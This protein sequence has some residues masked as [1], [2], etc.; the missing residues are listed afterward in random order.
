MT[1][2]KS[3]F[4]RL[5]SI[6]YAAFKGEQHDYTQGSINKAIVLLSIP[7]IIEMVMESLFAVIDI[8][9]VGKI[10]VNAIA[11]VAL[12][13]SVIMIIYSVAMGLSMAATALVAR[14]VGEKDYDGASRSAEQ[15]ILV[16]V[17]VALFFGIIGASFPRTILRLM[18]GEPD[19]IAEGYRYTMFM[20][21]GNITIML[22]FLI[23]AI[24]RGA[25]DASIAMRVLVLS[26][27]LNIILDPILIFGLG[28][29]PAFG[30]EG[31]AIAT[32]TGRGIGVLYQIYLLNSERTKIHL[33]NFKVRFIRP[34]VKSIVNISLGGIGQFMIGTVSW[35]LMVRISA[36]FGPDVLAGYAIAF[37]II[38]FTILP[39]WGLSNAAATLV[40]Q[41]LGAGNPERAEASVW[42]C[43]Y[44]NMI[45]LFA[46]SVIFFWQAEFFVGIFTSEAEVTRWGAMA[47]R[48][49]CT[50]YIFFAYGMVI[51]QAFNGAGDTKTPTIINIIC[52]WG[53]ELPLAYILAVTFGIGPAGIFISIA[54]AVVLVAVVSIVI[55]KK[56]KWK[57][58]KV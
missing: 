8:Y 22:I 17:A 20:F 45:F 3:K 48:Y 39:S 37:R 49:I 53:F 30:I 50:G 54:L 41:N 55:F 12:T 28:P 25:G 57:L 33:R 24:F 31:A 19:L 42:K 52:Y 18:G 29:I 26:N 14:R 10:S 6:F 9:F 47:L 56:G 51:G 36:E 7:M 27:V 38:V 35:L 13:E 34:I 4:S 15:A 5:L 16:A 11:T 44:Y 23:N 58:V 21:A 43:A 1:S 46:V 40:G 32:T 2:H